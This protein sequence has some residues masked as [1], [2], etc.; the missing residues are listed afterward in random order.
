MP[1][2]FVVAVDGACVL[3][4]TGYEVTTRGGNTLSNDI[5]GALFC[6][7]AEILSSNDREWDEE[8][9]DCQFCV[10]IEA[11]GAAGNAFLT[12]IMTRVGNWGD[13]FG[14]N[15]V[16]NFFESVKRKVDAEILGDNPRHTIT[17]PIGK[18]EDYCGAPDQVLGTADATPEFA[19][20][21]PADT[22]E[23]AD[24]V[25]TALSD[26]EEALFDFDG[27]IAHN[28]GASASRDLATDHLDLVFAKI[29][30]LKV[31]FKRAKRLLLA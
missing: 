24:H 7:T 20:A 8:V 2:F 31:E 12:P 5:G 13:I 3:P 26:L 1:T 9:R 11:D 22:A 10:P 29:E 18:V 21:D 30:E 6:G 19:D 28:T 17:S 25:D 27:H 16:D 4:D 23:L 15:Y 14:M